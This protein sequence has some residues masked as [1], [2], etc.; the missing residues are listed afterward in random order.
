MLSLDRCRTLLGPDCTLSDAQIERLR[1]QIRVMA[2]ITMNV[3]TVP[4][5]TTPFCEAARLL[6]DVDHVEEPAAILEFDAGM[7]RSRA[8]K[9]TIQQ[10]LNRIRE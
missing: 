8:E 7:P 10:V 5:T 3:M 2:E 1:D 4:D 9:T 6:P